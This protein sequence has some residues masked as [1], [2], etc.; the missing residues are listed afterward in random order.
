MRAWSIP[1]CCAFATFIGAAGLDLEENETI[2]KSWTLANPAQVEM[3]ID[4][5]DG[6]LD[7]TGYSGRDVELV[8]NRTTRAESAQRMQK[9]HEEV[10]L[11]L[12]ES[13]GKIRAF[14]DAPWRCG[15]GVN[16]RGPR[17]H[18]YRV[19][20]DFQVRVPADM[21]LFLR[22]INNGEIAVRNVSGDYDIE[23]INGGIEMV[24]IGGS[25]RAY[26]LNG[27][28]T[29]RFNRNPRAPSYYG[30]L[31]GDV[32]LYFLPNLA[33]DLWLKTFNG[34]I[35]TDFPVSGLP[36]AAAKPERRGTKFVYRS[37]NFFGVRV[38]AGGPEIKLD[39][40][41]GNIRIH[42]GGK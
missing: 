28:V 15:D 41:N 4:N 33:A 39:G 6:S 12:S 35:Y 5:I 13:E 14:V 31:N 32:D 19:S 7:V 8:A 20:Y 40:F 16:Y 42:E 29:I 21:R 22:T 17:H 3:A 11:D 18:G 27:A 34:G 30:S 10:R 1:V 38:G 24:E 25:G 23:N 36:A 37:N 9:A 2:R 26:A